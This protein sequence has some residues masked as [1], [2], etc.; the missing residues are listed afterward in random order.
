MGEPWIGDMASCS[1]MTSCTCMVSCMC[2]ACLVAESC[3]RVS[4]R[5]LEATARSAWACLSSSSLTR[6][7]TSACVNAA[8]TSATGMLSSASAADVSAAASRWRMSSPI[9]VSYSVVSVPIIDSDLD[10]ASASRCSASSLA[11]VA[12][13]LAVSATSASMVSACFSAAQPL[14]ESASSARRALISFAC[15]SISAAAA[16]ALSLANLALYVSF[17]PSA[18]SFSCVSLRT[19]AFSPLA[20][21]ARASIAANSAALSITSPAD[22]ASPPTTAVTG[23]AAV[24]A[25]VEEPRAVGRPIIERRSAAGV[26][27][28]PV[29]SEGVPAAEVAESAVEVEV[30]FAPLRLARDSFSCMRNCVTCCSLASSTEP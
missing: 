30:A 19:A 11:C 22:R 18:T 17:R 20:S 15:F 5:S 28:P 2:M 7:A 4:V 24:A 29:L 21:T 25:V 27:L 14:M 8:C 3:E 12:A 16:V 6:S 26:R 1:C 13:I 23:G 10:C 9:T